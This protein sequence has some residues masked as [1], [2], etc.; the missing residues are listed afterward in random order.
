MEITN[1]IIVLLI[2]ILFLLISLVYALFYIQKL[3]HQFE[4]QSQKQPLQPQQQ[5]VKNDAANLQLAA[6]ERLTLF[7]ERIKLENL[8]SRMYNS[9]YSAA[10][11]QQVLTQSVNEEYEYNLSQQLYIKP[12]VWEAITKLKE[13]NIFII[14][15]IGNTVAPNAT[16]ADFNSNVL[17]LLKVNE[18]ATM[19]NVVLN[20]LQFET[21]ALL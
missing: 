7:A 5:V 9:N 18:N 19:N 17:E 6:Y 10:Q 20:A 13:Q 8:V 15:Q 21:K 1:T 16:A 4:L 2:F 11:M 12:Q 3:K 14:N